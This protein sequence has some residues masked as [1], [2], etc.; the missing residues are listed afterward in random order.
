MRVSMSPKGSLMDILLAPLPARLGHAGDE[1]L[2]RQIAKLVA[3]HSD[4]AVVAA[5][6]A[7]Q[8]TAVANANRRRVAR[9]LCQLDARRKALFRRALQIAGDRLQALALLGGLRD[10]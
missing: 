4:L 6:A 10:E 2:A 8:L 3:A 5:R 1:A 7:R 9:H